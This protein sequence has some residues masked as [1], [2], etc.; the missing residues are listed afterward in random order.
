ME[1]KH[2]RF[3]GSIDCLGLRCEE[4]TPIL[5]CTRRQLRGMLPLM[6]P[7][8][9]TA[10]KNLIEFAIVWAFGTTWYFVWRWIR[11]RKVG[12]AM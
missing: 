2:A 11:H 8:T 4:R 1:A 12:D 5:R 10:G 6:M 7:R 3:N 9:K